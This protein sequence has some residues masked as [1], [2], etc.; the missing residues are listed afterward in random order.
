[1]RTC[2]LIS[3]NTAYNFYFSEVFIGTSKRKP[4]PCDSGADYLRDH[5]LVDECPVWYLPFSEGGAEGSQLLSTLL[6]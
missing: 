5:T 6:S 4:L 3:S 1:M 2:L